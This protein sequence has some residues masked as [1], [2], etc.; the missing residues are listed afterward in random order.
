MDPQRLDVSATPSL[1]AP[2]PDFLCV[3][4]EKA[5]TRW[6]Y[7]QLRW[8][9]HPDFWMPPVKELRYLYSAVPRM[10]SNACAGSSETAST[11]C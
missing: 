5:A 7:D 11:W 2:E 4:M 3:G 9:D 10:E 8:A 6:A 1:G